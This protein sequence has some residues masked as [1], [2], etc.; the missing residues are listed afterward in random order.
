MIPDD[1]QKYVPQA[2]THQLPLVIIMTMVLRCV[3]Y[4]VFGEV[5]EGENA[6]GTI[7][8]GTQLL[9]FWGRREFFKFKSA[10]FIR[11][12]PFCFS[13]FFLKR[14]CIFNPFYMQRS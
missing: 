13:Y 9:L 2:G 4:R 10:V 14:S 1:R 7:E 5:N 11:K 12:A 3:A 8:G 6:E